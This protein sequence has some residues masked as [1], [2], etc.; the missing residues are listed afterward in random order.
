MWES[1]RQSVNFVIDALK[2]VN[3]NDLSIK[4]SDLGPDGKNE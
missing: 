3:A 1:F 4:G 2:I